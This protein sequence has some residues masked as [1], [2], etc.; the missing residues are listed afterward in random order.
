[1]NRF[2]VP[3]ECIS[4]G[5]IDKPPANSL[6]MKYLRRQNGVQGNEFTSFPPFHIPYSFYSRNRMTNVRRRYGTHSPGPAYAW[7]S[8]AARNGDGKWVTALEV[9]RCSAVRKAGIGDVA[10]A[11]RD[12]SPSPMT[13]LNPRGQ[14]SPWRK[15]KK[16][17]I[18]GK[19]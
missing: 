16:F 3:A 14:V 10:I 13:N 7:R 4:S 18:G 9:E 6:A 1:M 8:R 5:G 19:G 15:G 11:L 17:R 2:L 12:G